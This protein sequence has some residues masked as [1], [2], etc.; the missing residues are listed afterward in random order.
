MKINAKIAALRNEY[1][2]LKARRSVAFGGFISYYDSEI[3][4]VLTEINAL[5][6]SLAF[7]RPVLGVERSLEGSV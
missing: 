3:L 4:K 2:G 1:E 5:E 7:N 6:L